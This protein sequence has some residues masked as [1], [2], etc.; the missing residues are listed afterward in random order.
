MPT[1]RAGSS[2][3]R[4]RKYASDSS[5]VERLDRALDARLA[6]ERRAPVEDDRRLRVRGELRGLAALRGSC[7][8]AGRARRSRGRAPC[9]PTGAPSGVRGRER[10]R[11]GLEETRVAGL[12]EPRAELDDAG[13]RRGS[14][15][16]CPWREC[17][18]AASA[19]L[20]SMAVTKDDRDPHRDPRAPLA[21]A[22]RARARA[23]AQPLHRPPA[24]LRRARRER[25]DHGRRR[26]LVRR[27]RGR[28]RRRQ[29]RSRAPAGRRGDRRAGA[30]FVHTDFTVVPYEPYV[31][32]AERLCALAP[33]AGRDASR[34]LQRGHGGGGERRQAR[35]P[36]HR[37]ARRDRVRGRIPRADAALDDDDVEVPPV[38]DRHGPVLAGGVPRAVPERV[39]RAGRCRGAGPSSSACSRRTWRPTRSRRS[40]SSRSSAR[41]VR[42]R[43]RASTWRGCE[44]CAT[45]RHRARRR[46]GADRLRSHRADVRDGA[47]R[48]R[49]RPDDTSRSR[50]RPGL[51]LSGVIGRAE[52]M[53][54]AHAG[55]IGGTYIGNPVA[56]AAA[57][58]VLDVFEEEGLVERASV[59]G[60][61]IRERMLELAGALAGDRR[62]PRTGSDARDRARTRSRHERAGARARARGD[63]RGAASAG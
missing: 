27:L 17:T 16:R 38:Q 18:S 34:V 2:V 9:A 12:G 49:A 31:A 15:A 61:R 37:A 48:R 21:R 13:P 14:R 29:R 7:R 52:I 39:P 63:R 8:S 60:D 40:S 53:D 45:P 59:V 43:V 50:S 30:R 25:D 28:R 47:L 3:S 54:G 4:V 51:P 62:R 20:L 1:R 22:A 32:L 10:R 26:Q 33:I 44:R 58:A 19:R 36:A 5:S 35:A 42:A 55:A 56:Q 41:G 23:V 24:D 57:L 46:R 6:P 11:L